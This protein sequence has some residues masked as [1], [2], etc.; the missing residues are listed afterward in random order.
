MQLAIVSRNPYLYSTR[1]LVEAAIEQHHTVRVVDPLRCMVHIS[2]QNPVL[3][4]N[5]ARLS[6]LDAVIPR[7]GPSVTVYGLALVRQFEMMGVYTVNDSHAIAQARDKLSCLQVLSK[8]H[9]NVPRTVFTSQPEHVREAIDLVG[10][11]PVVLKLMNSSQGMGV[12]LAD[13]VQMARSVLDT[14]YSLGQ[15]IL[16]QEFVAEANGQDLRAFVVGDRV[17]AAI[18]RVAAAG[19]FRSNLHRGGTSQEVELEPEYAEMAARA[20]RTMGLNVAGVDMLESKRGPMVLEVNSSP[21]LEGIETTTGADIAGEII[22]FAS[23]KAAPTR[24]Q[25]VLTDPP[26]N[27][28]GT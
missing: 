20:V 12:M 15:S 4:V 21:G 23:E 6:T 22:R 25:A 7:I 10:G 24:R 28:G 27:P 9:I 14:F 3:I 13:T 26:A 5:G 11:T 1:R 17:V 18:R 19:E 2:A 16:I 8:N